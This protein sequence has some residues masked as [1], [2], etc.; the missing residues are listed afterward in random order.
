MWLSQEMLLAQPQQPRPI[1]DFYLSDPQ[2]IHPTD[3][4]KCALR[5]LLLLLFSGACIFQRAVLLGLSAEEAERMI[6]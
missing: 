2:E 5:P 3:L 6:C 4:K 1:I